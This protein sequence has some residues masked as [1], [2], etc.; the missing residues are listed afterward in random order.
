VG[1]LGRSRRSR[2]IFEVFRQE[3]KGAAFAHAGSI[4][5]PDVTFAQAFAHE[6]YGRRQES[7]ALWVVPRAA[8]REVHDFHDELHK[9]YHRVD[10]YPLKEKLRLAR[11]RAGTARDR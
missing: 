4:E 7:E 9:T 5:A 10:G 3:K 2:V 1:A 11:E 6:Q 8:I